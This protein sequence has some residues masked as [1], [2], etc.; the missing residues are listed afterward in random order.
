VHPN[1]DAIVRSIGLDEHVHADFGSGLWDGGPIGIPYTTVRRGQPKVPVS[2]EQ[3]GKD[4]G[5]GATDT[6]GTWRTTA[7][8]G[9]PAGGRSTKDDPWSCFVE[10]LARS[11]RTSTPR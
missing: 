4:E 6:A 3:R 2:F 1:S 9:G 10:R 11:P 8:K 5:G 7:M